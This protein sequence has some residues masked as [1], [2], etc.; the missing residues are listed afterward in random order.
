MKWNN[1]LT[2]LL[3]IT[4]P[5][6]QAPMLGVT[7]PEMVAAV[8]DN[9]G[10]GSLPVGSLSPD[11]TAQ[12]IQKVKSYTTKPFAVNLFAHAVPAPFDRPRMENMQRF[13]QKFSAANGVNYKEQS[14]EEIKLYAYSEQVDIL[15]KED[16]KI[17]SFTFGILED[18]VLT[19]LK[20][21]G[22]ILIGTATCVE[23]AKIL[24]AKGVDIITAQGI[25]AGGHRGTF[26]NN[27]TIPQVG[28][29]ALLPQIADAVENPVLGA[30]AIVDGRSIA[31]AFL[32]G[33]QGVQVGSAFVASVESAAHAAYKKRMPTAKDTDTV[34]T[35]SITGRW[36][37]GIKNG[38]IEQIEQSG[39]EVAE[40]PYQNFLTA[41]VRLQGQ[42]K[43]DAELLSMWAGQGSIKSAGKHA[44]EIVS[45][46]IRETEKAF[47]QF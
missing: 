25:E 34:L 35:K 22:V 44:G 15:L 19:V 28:L 39:I 20:N 46:L 1:G 16:I 14:I 6:I 26:I 12:L 3:D 43:N 37:R 31:A 11:Q 7:T 42:S 40:Y 27:S 21:K 4:Y 29:F 36:A 33:A 8:S 38:L 24:S 9:G 23:E 30:G 18:D 47:E 41:P 10:L 17:V 2:K 32:L 45:Q 13:M 5:V